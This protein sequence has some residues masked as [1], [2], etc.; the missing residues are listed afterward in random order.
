MTGF[1]DKFVHVQAITQHYVFLVDHLDAK[2]SGLLNQLYQASVI[3]M[4][5]RETIDS[6]VTSWAQNER[7]LSI[8]RRKTKDLYDRFLD[9]LDTT[10]QQHIR[11]HITAL[12]SVHL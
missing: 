8:L 1:D 5:D 10:Q 11:E 6:E 12:G 4:E 7:L 9:A 2:N 3:S